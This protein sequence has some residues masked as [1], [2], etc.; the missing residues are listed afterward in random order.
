MV[1]WWC[2]GG[3]AYLGLAGGVGCNGGGEEWHCVWGS[4]ALLLLWCGVSCGCG[5]ACAVCVM[6]VLWNC[7]VRSGPF[8]VWSVH[9][10]CFHDSSTRD[11][12][13]PVLG[14]SLQTPSS[15][16]ALLLPTNE[17]ATRRSKNIKLII[18]ATK[19]SVAHLHGHENLS[20][21]LHTCTKMPR[22]KT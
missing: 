7:S 15:A 10:P 22:A 19:D 11:T 6:R 1:S 9:P 21:S 14:P 4:C 8:T 20:R 16:W 3:V 5:R 2:S 17:P 18:Q 12:L 13:G